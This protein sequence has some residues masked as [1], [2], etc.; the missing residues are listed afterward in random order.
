MGLRWKVRPFR[1]EE[2]KDKQAFLIVGQC[3]PSDT[4]KMHFENFKRPPLSPAA[5]CRRDSVKRKVG[6]PFILQH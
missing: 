1:Q 6:G 4:I 2:Q 3:K 5:L